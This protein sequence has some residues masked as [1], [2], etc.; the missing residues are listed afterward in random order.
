LSD[1]NRTPSANRQPHAADQDQL[2]PPEL[3]ATLAAAVRPVVVGH[4]TPDVD[5]MGSMLA[6][7]RALPSPEAM[8]SLPG[9]PVSQ[10]LRFM[11]ELAGKDLPIAGPDRVAQADVVAV[12]DTAGTNRVHVAGKWE[13]IADKLVVNIDHHIT[14]PDYGRLNWVVDN[15]SSSCELVHRLIVAAGWPL[16][17]IMASM[18]YAGIHADTGG[19]SLPNTT[20]LALESAA[21]LIRAGADVE[22]LGARLCRSQERHEFDLMRNVYRN[23]HVVDSGRIA[24]STLNYD[25]IKATGCTPDDIDDQVSIPRSLSGIRIAMLFSEGERGVIRINLRGEN[26]TPVITLAERL[27]GGGHTFS[28][29]ARIRGQMEPV[30]NRVLE[31]AEAALGD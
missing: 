4:I 8:I 7:A 17:P 30:V 21:A 13:A 1:S 10:K 24:Y 14:N 27:G 19:F 28:A 23:T 9:I 18:L 3:I 26:G 16:D 20:A 31:E 29:G 11:L 5:A 15:A 2:P 25:E 22:R 12:V 6:L